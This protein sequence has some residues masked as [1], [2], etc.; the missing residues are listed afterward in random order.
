MSIDVVDADRGLTGERSGVRSLAEGG[1][2]AQLRVDHPDLFLRPTLRRA[3]DVTIEPEYWTTVDT[4]RTLVFFTAFG[5]GE[6]FENA[7][8]M[9]PTIFDPVLVDRYPN[10][11]VYRA[12]LADRVVPIVS[13]TAAVDGRL[14]ECTS[15]RDGWLVQLRFPTR[16]AL[17]EFNEHCRARDVSVSVEHLRVSDD[18]DDGVIALTDKQQE[19]LA[20]AHEEGYFEVPRGISQDELAE[21]LGVSKSAV[22]QRLRRAIGKLCGSSLSST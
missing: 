10:R 4:G 11:R 20:V 9:D 14:L 1:I 2:I 13:G 12:A 8:A 5:A 22:S 3:P 18:E 17:V 15:S 19:L 6:E 7:L 21:R 16:D